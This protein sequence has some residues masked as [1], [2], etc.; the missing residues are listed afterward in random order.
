MFVLLI[1]PAKLKS[2]YSFIHSPF[3]TFH[4]MFKFIT[5]IRIFTLVLTLTVSVI[6]LLAN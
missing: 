1:P 4:S 6:Y 3:N 2:F 5:V